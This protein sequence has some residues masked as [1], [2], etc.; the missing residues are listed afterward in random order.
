MMKTVDLFLRSYPLDY[1]WLPFLFRSMQRHVRGFR[2]LI[3]VYQADQVGPPAIAECGHK[4]IDAGCIETFQAG[5]ADHRFPDDYVGQQITKLQAHELT[6]AD[7]VCYLDS[8]FVFIREFTPQSKRPGTVEARD[9]GSVGKAVCWYPPTKILLREEPRFETMARHPFQYPTAIIKR[10]YDH[11]GGESGLLGFGAHFSEFNLLGNFA[12]N[13]CG[14]SPV[15]VGFGDSTQEARV[16]D[17]VHQF[18]SHNMRLDP[19]KV[20]AKMRELGYWEG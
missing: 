6:S 15:T 14:F 4:L 3:I 9:W 5:P 12:I 10:C 18:W 13:H 16:D 19:G 17:W 1:C 2:A 7:E 20:E 11:V 8:D